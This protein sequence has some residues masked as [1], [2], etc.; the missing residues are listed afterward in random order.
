[1]SPF[2]SSMRESLRRSRI[3]DT[4]LPDHCGGPCACS[5]P[6]ATP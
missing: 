1:M 5:Q 4:C 6:E 3:A 2:A